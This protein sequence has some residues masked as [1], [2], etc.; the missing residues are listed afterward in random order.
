MAEDF[1]DQGARQ[2]MLQIAKAYDEM[3]IRAESR[4]KPTAL[5]KV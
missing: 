3:A 2:T 5:E 1:S 4:C